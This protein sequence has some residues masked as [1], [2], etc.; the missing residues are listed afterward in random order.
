[1]TLLASAASGRWPAALPRPLCSHVPQIEGNRG[2]RVVVIPLKAAIA[3]EARW[4][5]HEI[6]GIRCGQQGQRWHVVA[7]NALRVS[8]YAQMPIRN[9]PIETP[10]RS[11]PP[12]HEPINP[13]RPCFTVRPRNPLETP[14]QTTLSPALPFV[15]CV[16]RR[17]CR[18]YF[19]A[20][21][22]PTV[23]T[24]SLWNVCLR[25]G[26]LPHVRT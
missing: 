9:L 10:E 18:R 4:N 24:P 12:P 23:S 19:S 15:R 26:P 20:G 8:T 14:E 17:E 11:A 6:I 21:A 25:I 5:G 2:A 7:R 13:V 22:V 1:M 3:I 16:A